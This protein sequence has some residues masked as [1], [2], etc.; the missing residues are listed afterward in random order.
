MTLA[1]PEEGTSSL[2]E[3]IAKDYFIA[4]RGDRD[5]ELKIREREPRDTESAF[6]H[7]VRHEAYDKAVVEDNRDHNKGKGNRYRQ[8]DG[9]LRKMAQ[10]ERRLEQVTVEQPAARP[11]VMS[12]SGA[13]PQSTVQDSTV[14]E[15][16]YNMARLSSKND[17]LSKE[18]GRL[19][20][21]E[22]QRKGAS[23]QLP[24][25]SVDT[26]APP[27]VRLQS[28]RHPVLHRPSV[29]TVEASDTN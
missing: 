16:K 29:I 21:L 2:C 11:A 20:L 22:E 4:S 9:L 12:V 10:V 6:K 5:L 18:I 7:A 23:T 8:D 13:Q 28:S 19:R 17:E 27:R 15:L 26:H 3:Q 24:A 25:V 1:Y 14:K